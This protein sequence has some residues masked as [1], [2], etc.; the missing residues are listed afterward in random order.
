MA[1]DAMLRG[2]SITRC[3]ESCFPYALQSC[4]ILETIWCCRLRTVTLLFFHL[5]FSCICAQF[6]S[7][8][9]GC[10]DEIANS[11]YCLQFISE[12]D[13]DFNKYCL[14]S[15]MA[16]IL[17]P[18]GLL[19]LVCPVILGLNAD[20]FSIICLLKSLTV[21]RLIWYEPVY[22]YSHWSIL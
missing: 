11:I 16:M 2:F 12:P 10:N 7:G 4:E 5:N 3:V 21:F 20:R 22:Y 15:L 9:S 8:S 19:E 18:C 17:R 6:C 14:K 1:G 13:N